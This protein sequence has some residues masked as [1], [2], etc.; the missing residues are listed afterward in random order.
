MQTFKNRS[1]LFDDMGK[2]ASKIIDNLDSILELEPKGYKGTNTDKRRMFGNKAASI[3]VIS[4]P[5]VNI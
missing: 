1:I 3:G 5:Y 2:S 4:N